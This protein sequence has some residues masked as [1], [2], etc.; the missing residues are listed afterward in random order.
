ML[1]NK[2][3]FKL[4]GICILLFF[5]SSCMNDANMDVINFVSNPVSIPLGQLDNTFCQLSADS[6]IDTKEYLIVNYIDSLDCHSCKMSKFAKYERLYG[7]DTALENTGI[8]YIVRTPVGTEQF[9][10]ETFCKSKINGL[11]FFDT[12]DTFLHANPLLPKS[13]M[14]HSFVINKFGDILLVGDPF[15]NDKMKNL[16][17]KVV[18]REK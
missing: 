4:Q 5:C 3:K 2:F 9:L 15:K 1:K 12:N 18:G 10:Y 7:N 6:I 8:I 14:Y 17:L 11:V 13:N 16:L